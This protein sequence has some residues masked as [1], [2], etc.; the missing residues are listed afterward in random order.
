MTYLRAYPT[1]E[2]TMRPLNRREFLW[3]T[4]AAVAGPSHGA[5]KLSQGGF[6]LSH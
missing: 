1:E 3:A 4:A 6:K 2:K 5:S